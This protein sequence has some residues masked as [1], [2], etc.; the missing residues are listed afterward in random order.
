MIVK[1]ISDTFRRT[2]GTESESEK[3]L[4]TKKPK[5]KKKI[6]QAKRL[7]RNVLESAVRVASRYTNTKVVV[8]QFNGELRGGPEILLFFGSLQNT[9]NYSGQRL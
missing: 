1:A 6:A 3:S 8:D 4:D 5:L 2:F 9:L 7:P